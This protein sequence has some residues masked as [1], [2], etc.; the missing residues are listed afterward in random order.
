MSERLT[1]RK[2]IASRNEDDLNKNADY[3]KNDDEGF[4]KNIEDRNIFPFAPVV[5]NVIF[6][7]NIP[8]L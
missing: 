3:L 7:A 2:S 5:C 8:V 1:S 6:F 4:D